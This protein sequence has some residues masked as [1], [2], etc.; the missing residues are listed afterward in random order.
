MRIFKWP[1]AA[2]LLWGLFV[3]ISYVKRDAAI[4]RVP[5]LQ[6]ED[7]HQENLGF[8][9]NARLRFPKE[10]EFQLLY[11]TTLLAFPRGEV[12]GEVVGAIGLAP[13]DPTVLVRAAHLMLS[14]GELEVA[15]F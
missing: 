7:R 5:R 13:D 10:P 15:Q 11:A 4:R 9:D 14:E 6:S 2:A 12:A 8:L 1:A 3:G